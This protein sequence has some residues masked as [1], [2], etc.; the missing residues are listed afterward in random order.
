MVGALVGLEVVSGFGALVGIVVN[1]L[2]A[3]LVTLLMAGNGTLF[4]ETELCFL[5]CESDIALVIR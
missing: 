2:I 4:P 1:A 5:F 3:L